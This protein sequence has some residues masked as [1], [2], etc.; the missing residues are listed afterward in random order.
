LLQQD[1]T[2]YP[3]WVTDRFLQ[4]PG[5]IPQRVVELAQQITALQSDPYDKAV[6][7]ESYLRSYP[8]ST[9]IE[10]PPEGTD[11]VEYFLFDVKQGYC[12][13]YASAMVVMLRAVGIPSRVA[14]GYAPGERLP[15][16]DGNS[17]A[18]DTYRVL[19]RDAHAWVEAFFPTYGWIQ[20]EPTASQ[21]LLLR[22]MTVPSVAPEPPPPVTDDEDLRD[23]RNRTPSENT[24]EPEAP[25]AGLARWFHNHWLV[26]AIVAAVLVL[27]VITGVL[28]WRR[29]RAFLRSSE[30]L[31]GL[32]GQVGSWAARLRIPWPASHTA[33][34]HANQFGQTVPEA[35]PVVS[36]I[37]AL[38]AAQR[39]GR[40][41][42]PSDRVETMALE[43]QKLQ[44]ALWKKWLRR[45]AR[46]RATAP[47]T[48]PTPAGRGPRR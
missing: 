5:S 33:L 8:Y 14:A 3:T 22:L 43:W 41:R 25:Q 32:L 19:E 31:A 17:G 46:P 40:Q 27:V 44:P 36:Q 15:A 7:I 26:L 28:V 1:T 38:F 29:Q 34:E 9:D 42:P 12:D 24:Q 48:T 21:P 20:F 4:L 35:A 45:V 6:A 39:Y 23:L 18:T 16:E 47:S 13:Y 10:A 11:A 37:A 2:D 30:L